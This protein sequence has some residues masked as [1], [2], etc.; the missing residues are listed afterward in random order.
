MS[1]QRSLLGVGHAY[2]CDTVELD[3]T[4]EN[5]DGAVRYT[6]DGRLLAM[7]TISRDRVSMEVEVAME[8]ELAA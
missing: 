3:G 7:A 8:R 1:V 6:R 4:P 5:R 2:R